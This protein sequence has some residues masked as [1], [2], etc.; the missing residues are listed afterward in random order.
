MR[1]RGSAEVS[2]GRHRF[3][4]YPRFRPHRRRGSSAAPT[5]VSMLSILRRRRMIATGRSSRDRARSLVVGASGRRALAELHM[6][7]FCAIATI[8]HDR[9][10]PSLPSLDEARFAWWSPGAARD[11]CRSLL[12]TVSDGIVIAGSRCYLR[13]HCR[14]T[15]APSPIYR[16]GPPANRSLS[17]LTFYDAFRAPACSPFRLSAMPPRQ[18]RRHGSAR[19][20]RH[21]HARPPRRAHSRFADDRFRQFI[22]QL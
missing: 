3:V 17:G 15:Q 19:L 13:G 9:R 16:P 20:R 21:A 6:A 1:R 12:V 10:L 18:P 11:A 14:A 8:R 22:Q 4:R 2:A 7:R 5:Q